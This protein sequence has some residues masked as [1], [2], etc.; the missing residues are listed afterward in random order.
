MHSLYFPDSDKT[1]Y[2]PENISEC[3][4]SQFIAVFDILFKF[5]CDLINFEQMLSGMVYALLNMKAVN[6]PIEDDQN[7]KYINVMLL[8]NLLKD[9]FFIT[10]DEKIML[11]YDSCIN[12][13]PK[14]KIGFNTYYSPKEDFSNLLFGEYCDCLRLLLEFQQ[15]KDTEIIYDIVA[16]LYRE[17]Y[18]FKSSKSINVR[19]KFNQETVEKRKK[20]IKKLPFG[21]AYGV[22]M[23][24]AT[25]QR[26]INSSSISWGGRELDL[27]I[28]FQS[29]NESLSN[30][31]SIGMDAI[32]FSLSESQTFGDFNKLQETNV[33]LVLVKLYDMRTTQIEEKLQH[34]KANK[35]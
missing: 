2:I 22:F 28:L 32:L 3:N 34:E 27:S 33:W 20:Q 9:S 21:F 8:S 7:Q 11:K 26:I 19:K 14:I 13:I 35:K 30:L 23:W 18:F 6:N 4:E 16:I 15:S 10:E 25:F 1:I 24:F 5:D 31:P 29:D 17:K 12:P